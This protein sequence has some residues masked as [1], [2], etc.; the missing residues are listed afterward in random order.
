MII[1]LEKYPYYSDIL[2][3]GEPFIDVPHSA[4]AQLFDHACCLHFPKK[5]CLLDMGQNSLKFFII[6]RGIVKAYGYDP[7]TDRQLTLSLL[8]AKDVFDI[9]S[10]TECNHN[11]IYYE[12][13]EETEVLSIPVPYMKEWLYR[14]PLFLKS[15]LGYVID[16]KCLLQKYVSDIV[17]KDT[18]TRLAQLIFQYLNQSNHK[19]EIINNL[20]DKE[21]AAMIGTT[22]AVLNRH[23]QKFKEMGVL[24]VRRNEIEVINIPLLKQLLIN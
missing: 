23:M 20:T 18:S 4:L 5:T 10:L 17:L 7:H 12:T 14:N 8:T 1:G 11:H 16:K 3:N 9:F 22:R 24:E 15:F 19:I 6:I 21:W 2:K 13:L